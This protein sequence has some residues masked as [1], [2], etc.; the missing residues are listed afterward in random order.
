MKAAKWCSGRGKDQMWHL[1]LVESVIPGLLMPEGSLHESPPD[2][3]W[4]PP[5]SPMLLSQP[6]GSTLTLLLFSIFAP[7]FFFSSALLS[8][9]TWFQRHLMATNEKVVE[10]FSWKKC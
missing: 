6:A 1:K 7:I 2:F 10:S 5:A 9:F 3:Q 4:C 8:P